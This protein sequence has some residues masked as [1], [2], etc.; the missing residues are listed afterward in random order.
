MYSI[1]NKKSKYYNKIK[2]CTWI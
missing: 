2:N 1:L